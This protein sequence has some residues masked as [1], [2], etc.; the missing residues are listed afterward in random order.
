MLINYGFKRGYRVIIRYIINI[1]QDDSD[2]PPDGFYIPQE[3]FTWCGTPVFF[4]CLYLLDD[5]AVIW[6]NAFQNISQRGFCHLW[7]IPSSS[8]VSHSIAPKQ[9]QK[10]ISCLPLEPGFKCLSLC[11]Q[12]TTIQQDRV[13]LDIA[14]LAEHYYNLWDFNDAQT[15][16]DVTMNC[17]K[18]KLVAY[19]IVI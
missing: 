16:Q 12:V 7:Q 14:P 8:N 18:I 19:W 13:G 17:T 3:V 4:S 1:C 11:Q 15:L 5:G 9:T 2:I 6:N 10:S